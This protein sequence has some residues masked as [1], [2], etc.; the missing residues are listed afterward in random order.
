MV[1]GIKHNGVTKAYPHNILDWHEIVNDDVGG[2]KV[3][4]TY[5][6]LTGSALGWDRFVDGKTTTFGVSGLLYN[7]NLIPYDR[8]TGSNWSQMLVKGVSGKM[9]GSA[10]ETYDVVE[11]T[12]STWK[13]MYPNSHVLTRE[14]GYNRD[15]EVYPYGDYKSNHSKLLFPVTNTDSRVENKQRVLGVKVG[16]AE[17]AYPLNTFAGKT[18]VTHDNLGG[19]EIVVA[20][21]ISKNFIVAFVRRLDDGTLPEFEAV[22]DKDRIILKDNEG[23]EWDIFGKAVSGPRAGEELRKPLSYIAYWFAWAAF[24]PETDVRKRGD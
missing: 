4:L 23:N 13:E 2:A 16:N 7:N 5:C 8:N 10:P 22:Q 11:T 6:P 17:K 21:N 1:V 12:R 9:A 3:A 20:G 19:K 18:F 15:Y 24:Y 14:T